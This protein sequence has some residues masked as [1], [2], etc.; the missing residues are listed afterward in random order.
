M[1]NVLR[2]ALLGL[3]LVGIAMAKGDTDTMKVKAHVIQPL[4]VIVVQDMDFKKVIKGNTGISNAI[5][6]VE[7]E[8]NEEI[9]VDIPYEINLKNSHDDMLRTIINS[10]LPTRISEN[11]KVKFEIN[12]VLETDIQAKTGIYTGDCVIRVFYK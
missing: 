12:G 7:G 5:V 11:G 8:A 4:T 1:K 2:L 9:I 10:T 3:S 6:I